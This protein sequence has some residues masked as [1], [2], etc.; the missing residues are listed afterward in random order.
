MMGFFDSLSTRIPLAVIGGI[1]YGLLT[2]YLLSFIGVSSAPAASA[3]F[4]VFLLYLGSRFLLLFSGFSNPY[5]SKGRKHGLEQKVE[6]NPFYQ[7]SQWVGT[8]YHYHDLALFA[9]LILV[10]GF[11]LITLIVDLSSHQHIGNTLQN[12]WNSFSFLPE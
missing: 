9:F 10:A 11:F 12:L 6:G 8:F 2:Y 5:Y 7:T 3:G 1:L 4:F